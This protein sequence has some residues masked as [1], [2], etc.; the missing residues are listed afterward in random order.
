MNDDVIRSG[1][2]TNQA[3]RTAGHDTANDAVSLPDHARMCGE[4]GS[5]GKSSSAAESSARSA[6]K[7]NAG[8]IAGQIC[9]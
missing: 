2:G 5:R 6:I 4:N 3:D 1:P 8:A 7:S 9:S